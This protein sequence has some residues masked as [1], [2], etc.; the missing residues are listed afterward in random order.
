MSNN[1]ETRKFYTPLNLK[2]CVSAAGRQFVGITTQGKFWNVDQTVTTLEGGK[3]VIHCTMSIQNREDYINAICGV[4]PSVNNEGLAWA[5]VSFF[6]KLADRFANFVQKHPNSIITVTGALQLGEFTPKDS[7]TPLMGVNISADDF[8]FCRD[9][10]AKES[11]SAGTQSQG[12]T[13]AAPQQGWGQH[14]SSTAPQQPQ[15]GWGQQPS[16]PAPQQGS[17]APPETDRQGFQNL[18]DEDG[19]LPF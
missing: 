12:Y 2:R 17:Y 3:K 13:P 10:E 16:A 6:D 19:E 15:Q 1:T 8:F 9:I 18:D 4:R 14:G 11:G 7:T 5:R